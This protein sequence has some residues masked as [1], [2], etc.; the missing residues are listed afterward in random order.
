[1]TSRASVTAVLLVAFLGLSTGLCAQRAKTPALDEI[2]ERLEANLNRY[3]SRLPSLFCDEHAR[4]SHVA[5]GERDVST[6][7]DSV[8]RLKRTIRPDHTTALV[9]SREIQSVD[10]KPATSQHMDGPTLLSGAFEGGLAVVS[11]ARKRMSYALQRINSRRPAAPYMIRFATALTPQNSADC[12][13]Q[14]NSKGR[15]FI[16]P[17]SMQITRLEIMTPHHTIIPGSPFM[18]PVIGR[19]DLAVDYASVLLGGETF[20]LPSTITMRSTSGAGTFHMAVW[21]FRANYG[22]YH[23]LEV[24]SHILP[25]SQES[26]P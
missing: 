5:S 8:F 20:W 22:N 2:L 3:D 10:G 17:D 4:S 16:D 9:E 13:L 1:M 21:S 18:S 19:R 6:T 15:I 14:E 11:L 12:L 24:T 23:K 26:S 25:N 7:T